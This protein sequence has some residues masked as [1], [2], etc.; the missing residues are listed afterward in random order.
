MKKEK[1]S[2]RSKKRNDGLTRKIMMGKIAGIFS[3]HPGKTFNYK[4]LASKL[5]IKDNSQKNLI[6]NILTE[7]RDIGSVIEIA[8]GKYKLASQGG[9]VTGKV[10]LTM[11]GSGFIITEESTEDVF[12]NQTNLNHAL[13]GDIVKV[14]LYAKKRGKQPEGEVVE[15]IKRANINIVGVIDISKTFAF[16]IANSR[17]MPYDVFI[18]LGKINGA[19]NGDKVVAKITEWPAQ[20]RNPFGEV[21]EVLGKPGENETEMHAILAE[22]DLPYKFEASVEQ[23]AERIPVEITDADYKA[24]RDFRNVTTFTIDPVDAKD[25]DDA[26]SLQKLPNGNWEIGVHIADV[27]H[28]VKKDSVLDQEAYN[29]GTSVYL[30]DRV[31]PML[32]KKL[33]N[34]VC[35]LR[36]NEEK[37][38]YSIVFEMDNNGD[39]WDQWIGRT[40]IKSDKRFSYEEA[41]ALIEGGEGELK[42]EILI[43]NELA[44]KIRK[45]RFKDG[46]ISFERVEVKFNIDET[47]KPLGVFFKVNKESNQLI[48]EFMLLANKHVAAFIGDVKKGE[49][50]KTF[51]YRVHD[52]PNPDKLQIFSKFIQRF[53]YSINTTGHKNITTSIN[54]LLDEVQG[55]K[56]QNVIETLAVR[57]MAKAVYS[58]KN[59]GHYGLSFDFY[60][61]FTSPIRRYPDM[62]V[63]KLLTDYMNGAKSKDKEKYEKMCVYASEM[64]RRAAEAERA[65]I[66]YKQVEFMKDHV[67]EDFDGIISGV[68]EWGFYVELNESKCE[69]LVHIREL[70]DDYYF[71]DEDNYSIIGRKNKKTFQLG[72]PVR[73]KIVRA[74]LEKKQLDFTLALS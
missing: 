47:G 67:G 38:C 19:Q 73:I 40:V 4:Q 51:V 62:M 42:N 36:P 56:E 37:L 28:Y 13:N 16:I 39:I 53:G 25:F 11:K 58:T 9:Y 60:S 14:Y 26:L 33:S 17:Q 59:I 18:P 63:H 55:K 31:V 43:L 8:R 69:G 65:S 61:H 50:A 72:D 68:T 5:E 54:N 71:F 27:T 49:H 64:E 41:Q 15:I 7:L 70:D 52:K 74:D 46:A 20:Y 45:R 57:A 21:V 6:I 44:Q 48:E 32:P 24:R 29:R 66:K 2:N 30:V 10:E 34:N 3:N 1:K 22:F 23:E 35:S 12:V